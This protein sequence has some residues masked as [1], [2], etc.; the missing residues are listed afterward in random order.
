MV[1]MMLPSTMPVRRMPVR[2]MPVRRMPVRRMLVR[3]SRARITALALA[4]VAL[5]ACNTEQGRNER[6]DIHQQDMGAV[7]AIL[8]QDIER[9]MGG[10]RVAAG[11]FSRGF[12]VEDPARRERE[13]RSV[14]MQ[15]RNPRRTQAIPGLMTTPV[16][17]IAAVGTDG[18]VI[19]RDI[20]PDPM[21]GF[22]LGQ[23]VPVVRQ[24]LAGEGGYALSE[25]PSLEEDGLPS[26]T[27]V[28]AEPAL[29]DGEVVGVIAAGLP[30]WRIT[31]QMSRQLQLDNSDQVARGELVWA[32][33][34]RGDEQHYHGEFPPDLR[35]LIPSAQIRAQGLADSPGGFTGEVQQYGRWYGYGVLPIPTLG[36]DVT[37][38]LFRSDPV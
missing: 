37:V 26:V 28:F 10:T 15:L 11:R 38:I 16:S 6:R 30:L 7:R 4:V 18:R 21:R 19:A 22:D 35:E 12:L 5:S 24:A 25:I 20:E 14:L 31:Q 23:A 27:I 3:R 2:R 33:F 9:A 29:H 36:D 17:F 1:S 13:I 34:L 8:R 32:L